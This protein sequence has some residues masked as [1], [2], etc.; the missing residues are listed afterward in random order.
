MDALVPWG[1]LIQYGGG[2]GVLV[3]LVVMFL[4]HVTS[5]TRDFSDTVKGIHQETIVH[6]KSMQERGSV[7]AGSL[8]DC[9]QDNNKLIGRACSVLDRHDMLLS[10]IES[11]QF[12]HVE[13]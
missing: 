11:G 7:L 6:Q 1:N 4:R 3:F 8:Q 2:L 13:K 12:K 5:M 9:I 10:K